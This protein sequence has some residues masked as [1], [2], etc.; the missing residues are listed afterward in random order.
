MKYLKNITIIFILL[1][2]FCTSSVFSTGTV[3]YTNPTDITT[4]SPC[5]LLMESK[6]GKVVYEK[7]G[8][9]KMYPASTTKIMTAILTLEHCELTDVA[10]ASYE[11]VFTVPVGY[12]NA[13]IQVGEELTINQLLHV[14]LIS[15]AN[16]AANVLAEHI[17][18]SVESFATMMNTKAEEI[19]CLNTHFVN[20]NGVH[21]ENHYSTAYDLAIMGKYAMQN[22]TFRE[23]VA[24]TF[25]TLPS[26]NKYP[27]NDRVFGTTN[28]LIKKDTSDKVDNYYYEYATGAKTGY[29]NSAKNCIVATA[30]KDDIEYIVVI[31][32]AQTTENGL[33]ARYLDC[34]NLFNYAFENY[35]VK[36]I[37]EKGSILKKTKIAK[38]N[39]STKQLNVVVEDEISLLLKKDTDI[40]T[41]TPTVELNSD[42]KAPI[43][44]NTVI[45]KITYEVDGN[46]YTSNLLAGG[47]VVE[48]NAF[49][50]FLTVGSIILVLFLLYK[51][52][53]T[54]D[55]RKKR[56]RKRKKNSNSYS[57]KSNYLY[58]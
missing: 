29:T 37:N 52:L 35:K 36:T 13:N 31:L 1:T 20:A 48:S 10:T 40:N 56:K 46:T 27:T 15:S 21:N 23:I 16:E 18:G 38:A 14:L 7:N 11:A 39:I 47:N 26:T 28:E 3:T 25:Y 17:A 43:S 32:G 2:I 5:C 19:G 12:T 57:G 54:D 9:E 44:E 4:Y 33:S 51:L 34:K 22:E 55:K 49:N 50:T 42:L 8:Y 53:K 30:K 24:T 6:T 41:I 58:W 45:G